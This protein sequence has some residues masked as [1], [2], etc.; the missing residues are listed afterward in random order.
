MHTKKLFLSVICASLFAFAYAQ[1]D[2][3]DTTAMG[4][5]PFKTTA[6]MALDH[7]GFSLT[8]HGGINQFRG[9]YPANRFNNLGYG[10]GL[11]LEYN[12]TPVWGIGGAYSFDWTQVK[13]KNAE[14]GFLE[15]VL[16]PDGS[17]TTQSLSLN[18]G[19]LVHQGMLHKGQV[20]V[21]FNMVNAW[22]PRAAKDIFAFNVFAGLGGALYHNNISFHDTGNLT[23]AGKISDPDKYVKDLDNAHAHKVDGKDSYETAGFI[24]LGASLEFHVSRTIALGARVQYNMFLTD[25]IDNRYHST[26]NKRNDGSYNIDLSLRF[27]LAAKKKNHTMNVS[28]FDVLEEKIYESHPEIRPVI[29]HRVDTVV[30]MH[31]DTIV[32][33]HHDTV[34]MKVA[35]DAVPLVAATPVV[36][37]EP[38]ANPEIREFELEENFA[39]KEEAVVA[40][41]QSLSQLARKYYNNTFCWAFIWLANRNVAPDPNLILPKDP[42][43]IPVLTPE[44]KS[45]TKEEAKA[46]AAKYRNKK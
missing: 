41:G 12:F 33:V 9:D 18:A 42:L 8:I 6:N 32:I 34:V 5:H 46:I 2:V 28:S 1:E 13:T 25:Y 27:K 4:V 26:S 35:A 30:V 16:N 37:E 29:N 15:D 14:P 22:F 44:Q 10:G 19:D 24:P 39:V 23:A 11:N 7:T 40:Y 31:K 45:I 43:V 3:V 21:T 17:I 36:E 38:A 20:Y